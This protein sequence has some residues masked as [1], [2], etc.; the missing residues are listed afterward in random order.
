MASRPSK[1]FSGLVARAARTQLEYNESWLRYSAQ[2]ERAWR[3]TEHAEYHTSAARAEG[4]HASFGVYLV[5]DKQLLSNAN[6]SL[7]LLLVGARDCKGRLLPT[8][9]GRRD[10]RCS[11]APDADAWLTGRTAALGRPCQDDTQPPLPCF[12]LPCAGP[13]PTAMGQLRAGSDARRR[14]RQNLHHGHVPSRSPSAL[15]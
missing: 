12:C 10:S 11:A 8:T 7:A 13:R 4:G 5:Y 9:G 14:H 3:C 15:A 2:S 6:A 1:A